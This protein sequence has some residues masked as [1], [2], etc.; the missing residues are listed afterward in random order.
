MF[1]S[2]SA[3]TTGCRRRAIFNVPST[4]QLVLL[5][6][7]LTSSFKM[8]ASFRSSSLT[9]RVVCYVYHNGIRQKT[10]HNSFQTRNVSQFLGL[11]RN[12][13]VAINSR[14][15][16]TIDD[17]SSS[18][19][20]ETVTSRQTKGKFLTN[21]QIVERRL[22]VARGKRQARERTVQA[23]VDRNFRIKRLLHSEA[24]SASTEKIAANEDTY[25]VPPLYAVKVWVEP[26]FR[27][28]L[29]LSG[30]EKRGRVFIEAGSQGS[31][32]MRGLKQELHGFFS[33]LKKNTYLLRAS[34][35][36]VSPDGT[37]RSP[38]EA[39]SAD[40][41]EYISASWPIENNDDVIKTFQAADTF[42]QQSS[43]Q[44]K[45]PS[46]QISVLK[47]PNAPP[48]PPPPEY[49]KDMQDPKS[50]PTMTMISFY[51]FPPGGIHD[52]DAFAMDLSKK[53]KPFAALG[54][55][56]VAEEGVNAQMSVPTNVLTNFMQ[57]CR[58]ILELEYMEN[59]INVDP[60]PL[61]TEEFAVAG[62]PVN[63]KPSPPFRNLHIR[64]RNQIVAD[65]LLE[66]GNVSL[67]WQSAGYDMPPLEWHD[68]IKKAKLARQQS[69]ENV[70]SG[71]AEE[72]FPDLP[73]VL[74]CRN[75]YETDVGIF[76]GAEPL[77]TENFR[78]SWDVLKARLE[79]TPKD[80]PIMTYCTGGK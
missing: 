41:E 71:A 44:L 52:P 56:Y 55:V 17:R 22:A 51:A 15:L 6:V 43:Q 34:Y 12:D 58:S 74:D 69:N 30:R 19:N 37:L 20:K 36:T 80:A 65:G 23:R 3:M 53:W 66:D 2:S 72:N 24:S 11:A 8:V 60:K 54:R 61:T 46:I 16:A 29:K 73:I 63:G 50:S 1:N 13:M 25:P 38:D 57:C 26:D 9:R 49:L 35:P 78:D 75:K 28:E 18:S 42:F 68:K 77:D 64:V 48:P 21:E 59:D 62:V 7:L 33:S 45:R 40:G 5:C 70:G 32:T 27:H 67:D 14:L 10:W 39:G 31:L 76:D 4:S 79:D 47:D